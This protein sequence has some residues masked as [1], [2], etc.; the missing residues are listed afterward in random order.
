MLNLASNLPIWKQPLQNVSRMD[1]YH[2]QNLG[3]K[4]SKCM[5]S[6]GKFLHKGIFFDFLRIILVIS[7]FPQP[8]YN[9]HFEEK[10]Q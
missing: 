10:N 8:L 2:N 1:E 6:F 9:I 3:I 4:S 7:V 5:F